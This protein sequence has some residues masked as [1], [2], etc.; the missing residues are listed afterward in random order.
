MRW[1]FLVGMLLVAA[2]VFGEYRVE[3]LEGMWESVPTDINDRG[4]VCGI[5]QE[6]EFDPSMVFIWRPKSGLLLT[7]DGHE[8]SPLMDERGRVFFTGEADELVIWSEDNIRSTLYLGLPGAMLKAVNDRDQLVFRRWGGTAEDRVFMVDQGKIK[9]LGAPFGHNFDTIRLN[10][11][12]EMA[13]TVWE[14]MGCNPGPGKVRF[15]Q[16]ATGEA[17]DL[18]VAGDLQLLDLTNTGEW[19]CLYK[20]GKSARLLIGSQCAVIK[21]FPVSAAYETRGALNAKH[22]LCLAH[23]AFPGSNQFPWSEVVQESELVPI[24]TLIPPGA[25][26]RLFLMGLNAQG[27]MI[28][29]DY[30]GF[31]SHTYLLTPIE[32]D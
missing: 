9:L 5:Y 19:L 4:E 7:G 1:G 23:H 8:G 30:R 11:R 22:Q 6:G 21:S 20:S 16:V 13:A 31:G 27:Q 15:Y 12:G 25:I 29:L 18:E 10:N 26:N 24:E 2:T 28:G 32:E 17:Y 14:G 3:R